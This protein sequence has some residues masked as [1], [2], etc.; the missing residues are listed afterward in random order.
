LQSKSLTS[1]ASSSDEM[2]SS[3]RSNSSVSIATV[4]GL[5]LLGLVVI[6]QLAIVGLL[7]NQTVESS[8]NTDSISKSVDDSIQHSK[9]SQCQAYNTQYLVS[10]WCTHQEN[11]TRNCFEMVAGVEY[12]VQLG[13][14]GLQQLF[15][16][17]DSLEPQAGPVFYWAVDQSSESEDSHLDLTVGGVVNYFNNTAY[18]YSAR[19]HRA[20]TKCGGWSISF[21][22]DLAG[23]EQLQLAFCALVDNNDA[24][25]CGAFTVAEA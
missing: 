19:L 4:I 16:Y 11:Y 7:A 10:E 2:P 6:F 23:K 22:K 25:V 24:R 5:I 9:C 1:T 18:Y 20:S 13:E 8:D 21:W 17:M 3:S 12:A 14:K 15:D